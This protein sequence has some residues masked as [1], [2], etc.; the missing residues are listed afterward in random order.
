MKA[1]GRDEKDI[2]KSVKKNKIDNRRLCRFVGVAEEDHPVGAVSSA[3]AFVPD[4]METLLAS[5]LPGWDLARKKAIDEGRG[6]SGKNAA[7]YALAARECT[8]TP[9]EEL[10][11]L[12]AFCSGQAA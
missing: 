8:D 10:R 11:K 5:D 7:T 12:L 9:G 1:N 4:R 3:L 6:V 2:T